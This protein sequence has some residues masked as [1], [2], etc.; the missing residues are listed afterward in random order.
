MS[1]ISAKHCNQIVAPFCSRLLQK[2]LTPLQVVCA[3][4]HKL[5]HLIFGILKSGMPFDP[6]YLQVP[7]FTP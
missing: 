7:A 5:L 4:I 1:A 3:A 6:N 2:G